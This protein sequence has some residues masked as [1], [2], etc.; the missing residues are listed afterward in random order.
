MQARIDEIRTDI[1]LADVKINDVAGTRIQ[2]TFDFLDADYRQSQ[3]PTTRSDTAMTR[4]MVRSAM[5]RNVR[6]SSSSGDNLPLQARNEH[7]T[8]Q[9]IDT[10]IRRQ[11]SYRKQI[12]RYRVEI[13][14]KFS[15]PF[16]CVIFVLVG[17][18]LAIRMG[19]S[20]MGMAIGLS[21]LF[22]VVYYVG[23]IGGEKVADRGLV[24]P[25][26][27]MWAPNIIFAIVAII[28]LRQADREQS[29]RHWTIA[30][31]MKAIFRRNATATSR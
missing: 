30:N 13:H 10:Q 12:D 4:E 22:F 23:L 3:F 17:S 19:R 28:L 11:G 6:V 14:K 27:A 2:E 29:S 9:E 8:R 25:A 20:G 24:N 1:E 16:A 31:T 26:L 18:P 7:L 21:V 5:G 15:I